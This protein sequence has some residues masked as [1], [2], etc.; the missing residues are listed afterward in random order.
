MATTVTRE[1]V[2]VET[3]AADWSLVAHLRSH[4]REML[5]CSAADAH[6]PFEPYDAEMHPVRSSAPHSVGAQHPGN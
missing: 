6:D 3:G 1:E 2:M 5:P 4:E